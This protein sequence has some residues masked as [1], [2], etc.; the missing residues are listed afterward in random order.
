MGIQLREQ[1]VRWKV[2][3]FKAASRKNMK[4]KWKIKKE[5]ACIMRGKGGVCSK[6]KEAKI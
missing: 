5:C 2:T 6:I 1:E 4:K 3:T